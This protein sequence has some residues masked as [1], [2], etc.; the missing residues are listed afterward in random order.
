[1]KTV[2]PFCHSSYKIP[3]TTVG[4]A[5]RCPNPQCRRK[6]TANLTDEAGP[7]PASPKTQNAPP[8]PP[9]PRNRDALPLPLASHPQQPELPPQLTHAP[10]PVRVRWMAWT[11]RSHGR[12]LL[13]GGIA[14]GVLLLAIVFPLLLVVS[15]SA[16]RS[17]PERAFVSFVQ[18]VQNA[19]VEKA[20]ALD[21]YQ[22]SRLSGRFQRDI[23]AMKTEYANYFEG[24]PSLWP[25]S[26][27]HVEGYSAHVRSSEEPGAVP[28]NVR[29]LIPKTSRYEIL[30][31]VYNDKASA[32][33]MLARVHYPEVPLAYADSF[34]YET[35]YIGPSPRSLLSGGLSPIPPSYFGFGIMTLDHDFL[36]LRDRD[37]PQVH[38]NWEYRVHFNRK[39]IDA[40][41]LEI[42][43]VKTSGGSWLIQSVDFSTDKISFSE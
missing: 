6:F 8:P 24:N 42:V 32:A 43:A 16:G 21:A 2:C 29:L 7:K 31:I 41:E 23:A 5:V 37:R 17:A 25:G 34:R 28:L 19:D 13:F 14:T 27:P 15:S 3:E 39:N 35:V 12:L 26:N 18:A 11:E 40:M 22:Q 9:L 36:S 10:P 1:M 30:D 38:S 20:F 33:R 4:K